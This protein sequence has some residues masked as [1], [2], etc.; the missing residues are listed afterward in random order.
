MT[1]AKYDPITI[2][3]PPHVVAVLAVLAEWAR[4]DAKA[5]HPDTDRQVAKE[6]REEREGLANAFTRGAVHAL[7][8]FSAEGDLADALN[9]RDAAYEAFRV[10]NA[11]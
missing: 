10:D 5:M 4:A 11:E 1:D 8:A 7:P 3:R 2:Q 6:A 9:E